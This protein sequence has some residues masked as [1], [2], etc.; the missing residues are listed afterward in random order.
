[1]DEKIFFDQVGV[2]VT[3]DSVVVKGQTYP[4]A[5][6]TS[7]SFR[8]IEPKRWL[9]FLCLTVGLILLLEEGT[10][11]AV[12]GILSI[13]A[14]VSGLTAK[15][16]YAVVMTTGAGEKQVIT[17]EDSAYIQQ[18]IHAIDAAMVNRYKSPKTSAASPAGKV[19]AKRKSVTHKPSAAH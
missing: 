5:T 15:L 16:K 11:F 17:S 12:G 9:S 8:E 14:I 19:A 2:R 3:R 6:I 1:M 18:V 13:F 7:V 10:L 4:V